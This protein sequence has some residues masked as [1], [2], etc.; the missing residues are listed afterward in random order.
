M[1]IK[2]GLLNLIYIMPEAIFSY[3]EFYFGVLVCAL[4]EK[5]KT[6]MKLK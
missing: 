6:D 1:D 4:L 5:V 3:R 2:Q